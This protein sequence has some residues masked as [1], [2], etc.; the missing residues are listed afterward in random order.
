MDLSLDEA[1][2]LEE[3]LDVYRRDII[4]NLDGE[5]TLVQEHAINTAHTIGAALRASLEKHRALALKPPGYA[6]RRKKTRASQ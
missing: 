3:A 5:P 2:T 1:E 6:P 4:A